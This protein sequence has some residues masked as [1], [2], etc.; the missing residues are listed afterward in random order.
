MSYE[1]YAKI[2]DALGLRD[3]DVSRMAGINRATLP[4]WK[5]GYSEPKLEKRRKNSSG[6]RSQ[7][8]QFLN[9]HKCDKKAASGISLR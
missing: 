8:R 9:P 4:Q 6:K 3:A 2:R 7:K 1:T 5:G